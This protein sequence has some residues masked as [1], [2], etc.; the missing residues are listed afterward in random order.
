[1]NAADFVDW[2]PDF[3][4]LK[5]AATGEFPSVYL[6][7]RVNAPVALSRFA[8]TWPSKFQLINQTAT[9]FLS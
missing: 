9:L 7:A 4:L 1:M 6:R 5:L 2:P 3:K 8:K